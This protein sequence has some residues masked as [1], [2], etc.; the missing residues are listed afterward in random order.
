MGEHVRTW[1]F[2]PGDRPDRC[3]KALASASDQVIWDLEDAVN[4]EA[5]GA[6][7][8]S[9]AKLLRS[10]LHRM[11]WIRI[12]GW[13]T[14]WGEEDIGTLAEV[15]EGR[16]RWVVPKANA[17]VVRKLQ[18][19]GIVGKWLFIIETAQGLSDLYRP[20]DAWPTTGPARLALGAVDYRNDIGA[21]ETP[22]ESELIFPRSVLAVTS[23]RWE[24]AQPIDCGVTALDAPDDIYRSALRGKN[25]GMGGKLVLHPNQIE[26][27]H[28]AYS[29]TPDEMRWARD[30]VSQS[31]DTGAYSLHGEVVDRPVIQR[32]RD[33]LASESVS[34]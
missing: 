17:D 11:P 34:D 3:Q 10:D 18:C 29:I 32:A 22:D 21:R 2:A 20:D 27:T 30:I 6:A 9:L 28:R 1:L 23:R 4:P 14:A 7:R 25:L 24:W 13:D 26:P 8:Q 33:I 31:R 15:V 19:R 16:G 5:K 12:N